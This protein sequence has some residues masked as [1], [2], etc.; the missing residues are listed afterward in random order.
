MTCSRQEVVLGIFKTKSLVNWAVLLV[1]CDKETKHKRGVRHLVQ[2]GWPGGQHADL[3]SQMGTPTQHAITGPIPAPHRAVVQTQG[4][5]L[6]NLASPE[7]FH[8]IFS[9]FRSHDHREPGNVLAEDFNHRP[10]HPSFP[11]T[12]SRRMSP[13]HSTVGTPIDRVLE[14]RNSCL[15]PET[16]PQED[17]RIRGH[18]QDWRRYHLSNVIGFGEMPRRDLKMHLKTRTACLQHD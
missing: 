10:L 15:V 16:V 11:K 18:G 5:K 6:W 8:G 4:G 12:H 9:H 3:N 7:L 14:H 17:G 2:D 13:R 1:D